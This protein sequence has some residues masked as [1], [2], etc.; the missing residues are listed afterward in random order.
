MSDCCSGPC[1]AGVPPPGPRYRRVLWIALALNA[2][3]FCVELAG[4][5]HAG[6]ASLLA[7]AVDF[8]GDA[9]NYGLSLFVL[10]L[11]TVWRSRMALVKGVS[12]GL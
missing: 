5:L 1:A 12:M 6:S 10:G 9:A 7:D 11:A 4:G 8:F 3:M 2:A